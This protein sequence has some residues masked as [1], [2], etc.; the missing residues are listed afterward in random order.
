MKDNFMTPAGENR[1]PEGGG[2]GGGTE[3]WTLNLAKKAEE[4][5]KLKRF[6]YSFAGI[7]KDFVVVF[8]HSLG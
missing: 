6:D 3:A 1:A 7:E 5:E 4:K 2:G 8:C